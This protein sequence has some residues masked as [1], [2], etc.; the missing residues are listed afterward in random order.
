MEWLMAI[1][2]K[3]VAATNPNIVIRRKASTRTNT[4]TRT[5]IP[6]VVKWVPHSPLIEKN[7]IWPKNRT[8]TTAALKTRNAATRTRAGTRIRN[9]P[10][11]RRGPRITTPP[12]STR[13]KR[14]IR[15]GAIRTSPVIKIVNAQT[16]IKTSTVMKKASMS[17]K[18]PRPAKNTRA[19]GK[20]TQVQDFNR[21]NLFW[22]S[23]GTRKRA[24]ARIRRE[25][26]KSM[27][28]L[29]KSTK[30]SITRSIRAAR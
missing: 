28:H 20:Y 17:T 5:G 4:E 21:W 1:L 24:A 7:L 18:A 29:R 25:V 8:S 15:R 10:R 6:A 3:S 14:R 16:R 26:R 30:M 11:T 22:L 27:V 19:A 9:A 13:V 23:A 2:K 12:I